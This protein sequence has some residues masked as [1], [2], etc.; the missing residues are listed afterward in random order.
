MASDNSEPKANGENL[1]IRRYYSLRAGKRPLDSKFDLV[2]LLKLFF[3]IY[4]EFERNTE[5]V[6]IIV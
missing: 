5:Q 3:K 6:K 2:I 4:S 1:A